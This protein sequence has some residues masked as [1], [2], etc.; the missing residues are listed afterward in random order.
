[1]NK[2]IDINKSVFKIAAGL[3]KW[4]ISRYIFGKDFPL[5]ATFQLTNKCNFNCRM[6]NIK[7][8]PRQETL[9]LENFRAT[10]EQLSKMGTLYV[11]LSGGEPLLIKNILDYVS[12]AKSKIPVVNLV[13]NGYLMTEEI[14]RGLARARLDSLSVSID[15]LEE[16]HDAIRGMCGAFNR[17]LGAIDLVKQHAPQT[18]ITVNTVISLWNLEDIPA[19][20]ELT[21]KLGLRHKF[22][23]VYAHPDFVGQ[24][25]QYNVEKTGE[26]DI[27][28][29]KA[30]VN[31]LK[32]KNNVANSAYF[33]DCLPDYFTKAYTKAIFNQ[34]CIYPSFCCE[35]LQDGLMYPCIV[36]KNWS[37]GFDLKPGIR[38]VLD[39][40]QW[41]SDAKVLKSCRLCRQ[42]FSVCYVE[43]RLSLPITRFLRYNLFKK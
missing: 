33:L 37:A 15:A 30:L 10:I 31:L 6:C 17:A 25:A 34:D 27:A 26:I 1:M 5:M 32:S 38:A 29:V 22:Q 35:F 42:N 13:T 40:S 7:N 9:P 18:A 36:G 28:K 3:I 12:D 20:V 11:T 23:P 16:S 4:H 19:L 21:A 43:T 24:S 41:R 14:A 2:I 39:S 8:N